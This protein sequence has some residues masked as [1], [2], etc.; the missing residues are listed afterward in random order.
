MKI[1]FNSEGLFL[2]SKNHRGK[3]FSELPADFVSWCGKNIEG[4]SEQYAKLLRGESLAP[5]KKVPALSES[6]NG[7]GRKYFIS[8]TRRAYQ[9]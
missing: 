8:K 5:P 2:I 1:L 7:K 3:H 4:F 6:S 9:P